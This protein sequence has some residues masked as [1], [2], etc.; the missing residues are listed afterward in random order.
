MCRTVVLDR[1]CAVGLFV[2]VILCSTWARAVD[3]PFFDLHSGMPVGSGSGGGGGPP[4]GDP[5]PCPPPSSPPAPPCDS[6]TE[7]EVQAPC[8]AEK[9]QA[10]DPV[11]PFSGKFVLTETDLRL[12]GRFPLEIERSYQTRYQYNGP[13]GYGW[14]I[15][16]N[17]RL[18]RL[19]NTNLLL[20]RGD[21][22][23]D[24]FQFLGA[25]QYA[26]TNSNFDTIEEQLD[27]SYILTAP[28]GALRIYNDDGTLGQIENGAG[29]QWLFTYDVQGKLPIIGLSEFASVT[30]AV[31]IARDYQLQTIQEANQ[32]VPT[33]RRLDLQYGGEGRVTNIT[34]HTGADV[35][36][37]EL[38]YA[39]STN[40]SGDLV[41]FTDVDGAEFTYAYDDR[42]RMTDFFTGG[43]TC[44]LRSNTYDDEDRVIQQ[45]VGNT[46]IDFEYD[47]APDGRSR[48]TT[49]IVDDEILIPLRDQI[50]YFAFTLTGR[51]AEYVLQMGAGLDSEIAEDDDLVT[52]YQFDPVREQLIARGNPDGS[53]TTFAHDTAG[54]ITTQSVALAGGEVVSQVYA[55]DARGL[56]TNQY[57]AST[58][59]P[60]V[61]FGERTATYDGLGRKLTE[62]RV[63]TN[64]TALTMAFAYT[65]TGGVERVVTTDAE[66]HAWARERNM[67]GQLIHEYDPNN[68]SMQ[69]LFGYD[70]R[71]NR[72]NTVDALGNETQLEYDD[73]GRLIR[74]VDAL[75]HE[76]LKTYAA[77]RLVQEEVGRLGPEPGRITTFEYSAGNRLAATY[78]IDEGGQSNLWKRFGYDSEGY[79]LYEENALGQ[80]IEYLYDPANRRIEVSDIYG[81]VTT[82]RYDKAGKLVSVIDPV[83]SELLTAYDALGRLTNRVES[84]GSADQRS[85]AYRYTPL[86]K[87]LEIV[88]PD[89][90]L[91][92][93]SYD[94]WA[95][96]AAVAGSR[97]RPRLL[98]YDGNDNL[99][100]ETDGNGHSVTN[101]YDT[102]GR[103]VEVRK[104]D[105]SQSSLAYDL[106]GNTVSSTD[107]NGNT[108]FLTYDAMSRLQS[109][110]QPN[111][112]NEIFQ[113]WT[114]SPWNEIVMTSNAVGGVSLAAYDALGRQIVAT[115]EVGLA[116]SNEYNALDLVTSSLWPGGST[117][118]NLFVGR[119]LVE[120]RN[121]A[122][123]LD[124]FAYDAAGRLAEST[125]R[126]GVVTS[127][128]YDGR[129]NVVSISNSVGQLR[130]FTYDMFDQVTQQVEPDGAVHVREYDAFGA[131]TNRFG[132]GL[133]PA[134][135][136]YDAAG[137]LTNRV[138]AAGNGTAWEYDSLNRM[139]RRIFTDGTY[140]TYTYDAGGNLLAVVDPMGLSRTNR[141]NARNLRTGTDFA[142]G[143]QRMADYDAM[144]RLIFLAQDGWTNQWVHDVAGRIITNIQQG[145]AAVVS[146]AYNPEGLRTAMDFNG[147]STAYGYDAAGRLTSISNGV[148]VFAYT[149]HSQAD[150]V[151]G[152]Q[153]PNGMQITNTYDALGRLL[154]RSNLNASSTAL[155][156]FAYSHDA[157]E[158]ITNVVFADSGER[159]YH[160]DTMGQLS[161]AVGVLPGG[162][163]DADFQYQY[164]YDGSG[165][166]TQAVSQAGT[167]TFLYNSLNQIVSATVTAV[168]PGVFTFTHDAAGNLLNND[169]RQYGWTQENLLRVLTNGT[170]RQEYQYSGSGFLTE[171]RAYENDVLQD[172]VRYVYD[173]NLVLAE[174]DATNGVLRTFARGLDR[175]LSFARAG[176]MGGL[177]AVSESGPAATHQFYLYDG[178]GSVVQLVDT[179]QQVSADY[180]YDPY[181]RIR[182]AQGGSA[183]AN[184][185]RFHTKLMDPQAELIYFGYRWYS[186]GTRRW[187]SRDP[188]AELDGGNLYRFVRNNPVS[189]FDPYGL[190]TCRSA[191]PTFKTFTPGV[192]RRPDALGDP[193]EVIPAAALALTIPVLDIVV[194]CCKCKDK[195]KLCSNGI[196][197]LLDI[198]VWL[199]SS[200]PTTAEEE[201]TK[202]AEGDHVADLEA[203][204]SGACG[205]V[206]TEVELLAQAVG[207]L[208]GGASTQDEC[209]NGIL[210]ALNENLLSSITGA[211]IKSA[212]TWDATGKHN[213]GDPNQ[214]P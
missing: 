9:C 5:P 105:G 104:A 189:Q 184:R 46:V 67:L 100:V 24:E 72:T 187:I 59:F 53:T 18:Y 1:F 118:S 183:A 214:R 157:A 198:E 147:I 97:E 175:G 30:T 15:S 2:F 69:A 51:T 181:G 16:Q 32:G 35:P 11:Y 19:A 39:Y 68:P 202:R 62:S 123:H 199:K 158:Q 29:D 120:H 159:A 37:L 98:L 208:G 134:R 132:A 177:L 148:G 186:P 204:A 162:A 163:P 87:R 213:Y 178:L 101:V 71:G 79:R 77:N 8:D 22:A 90:S 26:G 110:S 61:R 63:G 36:D 103:L 94:P 12:P 171:R 180:E 185:T 179:N 111:A 131:L 65:M 195:W 146:Y 155:S 23:H 43:C 55:H 182:A 86:L 143:T 197:V 211:Q 89:G 64:G 156:S 207:F 13:F 31:V 151:S 203:W 150:L 139:T 136:A 142:D 165:N 80:R 92:T 114:Y 141:Y 34:V 113:S 192:D 54:R 17:E 20:R 95:R 4:G 88:Q 138:D 48:V 174:L 41:S 210:D 107:G 99:V 57:L 6:G 130:S 167:E 127:Y 117:V 161:G 153:Y 126:L 137:N 47:L 144:G 25:G 7:C 58:W 206:A 152:I 119:R 27:G 145:A 115:N 21:S 106:V 38:Y 82:N 164:G 60:G 73:K 49:H 74:V 78:R 209:E 76:T 135:F 93:F 44:T 176:G 14:N 28:D 91:S 109:R 10:A 149:W 66:G 133:L 83:G 200:Y 140:E 112:S 108:T 194:T 52:T 85:F 188:L 122:G 84:A 96:L 40:G 121:R 193:Q 42:H 116:V 128:V 191:G 75:G 172:T 129:G 45:I 154:A 50:E 201:W 166:I 212:N 70:S 102:Y 3:N 190:A 81:A 173:G 125:N 196:D 124:R 168:P 160:Y 170:E 169:D 205:F 33:G 56:I